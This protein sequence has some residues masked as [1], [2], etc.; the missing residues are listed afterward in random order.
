[1]QVE[2]AW[3]GVEDALWRMYDSLYDTWLSTGLTNSTKYMPRVTYDI[4]E[5][6]IGVKVGATHIQLGYQWHASGC[7]MLS[8]L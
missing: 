8:K 1:M 2:Q 3:S 6:V 7:Y 4:T 5:R